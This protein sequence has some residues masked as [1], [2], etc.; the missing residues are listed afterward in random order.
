MSAN[1]LAAPPP[2][3]ASSRVETV[4][5]YTNLGVMKLN[6]ENDPRQRD[7]HVEID[8]ITSLRSLVVFLA[9][10]QHHGSC[11]TGLRGQLDN[12]KLYLNTK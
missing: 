2:L 11:G 10:Q 5:I 6:T 9:L 12:Y 8:R 1:G 3:V 4:Q 7:F